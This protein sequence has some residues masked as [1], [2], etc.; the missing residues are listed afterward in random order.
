MTDRDRSH[1]EWHDDDEFWRVMEPVVFSRQRFATATTDVE[2][3]VELLQLAPGARV[4]DL[5]CGPGRHAVELARHGFAVT[6]VDRMARYLRRARAQAR[7]WQ[8]ELDLVE[9]DMR[10]FVRPGAFDAI[11]NLF[12]S[13]GYFEDD[14]HNRR[15]LR[16]MRASLAPGGAALIELL[17]KESVAR[18]WRGRWWVELETGELVCEER[19]VADG[20]DRLDSRWIVVDSA[21]ARREVRGIQ[22]IY[23]ATEL[24][25][26]LVDAGLETVTLHGRL[27]GAPHRRDAER[28]VAIARL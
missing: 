11:V 23:S 25:G 28:L 21:G 12:T 9:A 20:F 7:Q 15:V 27:A 19:T 18:H 24:R 1:A 10:E 17:G 4:L 16:N 3:I 14:E 8:D 6:G 5:C 2:A 22:R 13:F 26:L